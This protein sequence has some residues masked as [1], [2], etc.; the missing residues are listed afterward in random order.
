[1]NNNIF[2]KLSTRYVLKV[3]GRN[4]YRFIKKLNLNNID[5]LSITYNNIDDMDIIINSYDYKKVLKLKTIYN[6]KII[7][8][9]GIS[10]FKQN[11][12]KNKYLLFFIFIGITIIYFLSNVIFNV[13]VIHS[14]KKLRNLLIEELDSYGIKKYN[15]KKSYNKLQKIKEEIL[16]KYKDKIEWLEIKSNGTK[17]I[18]RVEDR[19]IT[20]KKE[21]KGLQDI[22]SN[23]YAT[24]LS[25]EAESGEVVKNVNDYV[26][27]GDVIISGSIKLNDNIKNYVKAKG[28][29]YGEV[30]Y[31][32]EV[33]Y[34]LYYYEEKE[35]GNYKKMVTLKI[36]NKNIELSFK[37]YKNK[38]I[39]SKTLLKSNLLPISINYDTVKEVEIIEETLTIEE[40]IDK[41]LD[42]AR[43][44]VQSTL[45]E[46]EK[47]ISVN[48]LK[49]DENNSKIIVDAFVTVYK[50]IT[51]TKEIVIENSEE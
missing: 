23:N 49:V 17:Y 16:Y 40:A 48:K 29:V 25:I 35:T 41:A 37:H 11:V 38:N 13:E 7:D 6:I 20:T 4:V 36:L 32:V 1:M 27:P 15:F 43:S 42:K 3:T 28:K 44:K 46:K 18:V 19:I 34:P 31:K 47:I 8:I 2:D 9:K 22:V 24:I 21:E 5:L 51:D 12:I 39:D 45:N 10:K 50:D 30:W 14:N 26:K 33:E